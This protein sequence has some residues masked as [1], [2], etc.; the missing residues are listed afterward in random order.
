MTK[1]HVT[2][3]KCHRRRRVLKVDA[4]TNAQSSQT[5]DRER[6]RHYIKRNRC[7]EA[8]AN[9]N[10]G[11]TRAVH[12]DA[13]TKLGAMRPRASADDQTRRIWLNHKGIDATERLDETSEHAARIRSAHEFVQPWRRIETQLDQQSHAYTA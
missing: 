13:C 8:I 6:L 4:I 2:A 7:I 10:H 9:G 1:H 5:C 12:T 11:E 3:E